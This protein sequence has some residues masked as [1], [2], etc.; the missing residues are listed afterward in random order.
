MKSGLKELITNESGRLSKTSTI[1]TLGFV[2][3]AAVLL[4]A[5]YLNRSYVPDLYFAFGT[6]CGG[7]VVTKGAVTAYKEKQS[8][9][10]PTTKSNS[11]AGH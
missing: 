9:P 4:L 8:P 7:L 5:V 1:Q 10:T 3:M 2:V 11:N 6:F